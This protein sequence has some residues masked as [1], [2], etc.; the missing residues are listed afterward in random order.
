M[1]LCLKL[2][3]FCIFC[4]PFNLGDASPIS[5]SSN[6]PP[7]T[8]CSSPPSSF[9]CHNQFIVPF[10]SQKFQSLISGR[11]PRCRIVRDRFNILT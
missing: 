9:S 1:Q 10:P 6:P 7:C 3:Y 8:C 2:V 4:I 5:E 11:H